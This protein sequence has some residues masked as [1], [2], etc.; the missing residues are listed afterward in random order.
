MSITCMIVEQVQIYGCQAGVAIYI[1]TY[2]CMTRAD[3]VLVWR[4]SALLQES[5]MPDQGP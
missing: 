2:V 3:P 5:C 4:K 1:H